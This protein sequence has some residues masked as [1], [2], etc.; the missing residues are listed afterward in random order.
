MGK[1]ATATIVLVMLM[2]SVL[3][4]PSSNANWGGDQSINNPLGTSPTYL[5][6]GESPG[7]VE[8]LKAIPGDGKV[9]VTW[10]LTENGATHYRIYRGADAELANASMVGEVTDTYWYD[11]TVINGDTYYYFVEPLNIVGPGPIGSVA[12]VPG[13]SLPMT[14]LRID[15]D[16]LLLANQLFYGWPGD[17]SVDDPITIA[18]LDIDAAGQGDGI[19]IGGTAAWTI[20]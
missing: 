20:R 10:M 17:G 14:S 11:D 3:L 1:L 16:G 19:F 18:G 8:G 7:P 12:V 4:L 2:A 9:L 15:N 5:I 13:T 6:S